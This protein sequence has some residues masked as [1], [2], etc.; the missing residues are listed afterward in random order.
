MNN[1]PNETQ[2]YFK[3]LLTSFESYQSP[4]GL[5]FII[6]FLIFSIWLMIPLF[7]G[8]TYLPRWTGFINPIFFIILSRIIYLVIPNISNTPFRYIFSPTSVMMYFFIIT[9]H[10]LWNGINK[11]KKIE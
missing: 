7:R 1:L 11:E 5:I 8:K 3:E 4:M 10:F 2:S 6:G 9:T